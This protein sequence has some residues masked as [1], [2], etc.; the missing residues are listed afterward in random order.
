[1]LT[2]NDC[3]LLLTDLQEKGVD[4]KSQLYTLMRSSDIN[5]DV[6]KFIND[7]R[8]LDVLA[9]YEKL[10][11]SHNQKKSNLYINIL[12]SDESEIN[13][14][15]EILTTLSA[16]LTQ[17]LLF[18][19]TASD[20]TMFLKHARAQEISKVLNNYFVDYNLTNCT[21][22]LRLI[23]CDLKALESLINKKTI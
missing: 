16:M 10:R 7:H 15:E 23:K 18:A 5:L 21:K 2:K 8:Q 13:N 17:I 20:K 22:L 14:P 6:L 12:K 9:F 4:T 1:M 19:R 3:I 11:K